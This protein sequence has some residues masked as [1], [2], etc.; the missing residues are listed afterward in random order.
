MK[1]LWEYPIDNHDRPL[2]TRGFKAA[3]RVSRALVGYFE[4]DLV[5]SSEAISD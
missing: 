2:E 1:S 3:N 5:L 4:P